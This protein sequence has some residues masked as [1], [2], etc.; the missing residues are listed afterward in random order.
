MTQRLARRSAGEQVVA[1]AQ[2]LSDDLLT[3]EEAAF[4]AIDTA[5]VV[6]GTAA[7]ALLDAAWAKAKQDTAA[8]AND[9]RF[10]DDLAVLHG[11]VLD[12]TRATVAGLAGQVTS[13]SIDS[14]GDELA[15][16]EQTLGKKYGGLSAEAVVRMEQRTDGLTTL[17]LEAYEAAL[18]RGQ[19]AFL[20]GLLE[21]VQIARREGD[22]VDRIWKRLFN[23]KP[24]SL[25][26][27]GGR[28][29]WWRASSGLHGAAQEVSIRLASTVRLAAMEEFNAA[30]ATR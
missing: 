25:P 12:A 19:Q 16:C 18:P 6:G 14:I 24:N 21:Q 29:I 28:G 9:A 1:R 7:V 17:R 5:F 3:L 15:L 27:N 26:G 20:S 13:L 2:R 10:R 30:G 8:L 22:G 4:A 23:E 11:Q